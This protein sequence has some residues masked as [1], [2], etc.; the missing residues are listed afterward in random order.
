MA[1]FE[2]DPSAFLDYAVDWAS[3]L[4]SDTIQ[5]STWSVPAGLTQEAATNTAAAATIWLSGGTDGAI[6]RVV[7]HITTAG[8]RADERTLTIRMR[9]R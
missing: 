8:G 2:K 3:W 6:Y 9:N 7:N 1:W 4:G 5:S